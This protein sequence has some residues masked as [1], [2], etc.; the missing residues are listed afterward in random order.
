[1]RQLRRHW[2]P[3]R[4]PQHG[5]GNVVLRRSVPHGARQADQSCGRSAMLVPQHCDGRTDRPVQR[6]RMQVA[7]PVDLCTGV[8]QRG[9]R[10]GV[11]CDCGTATSDTCCMC[12]TCRLKAHKQCSR[13]D[14]CCDNAC[15][16]KAAGMVCRAAVT[17]ATCRRHAVA[18]PASAL[19]TTAS[20]GARRARQPTE[21]P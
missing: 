8:R 5:P 13:A 14:A 2:R 1:M 7:W 15:M 6:R 19:P 11:E 20:S 3:D 16:F 9:H 18:T 21:G 12:S 4:L 10:F 17:A